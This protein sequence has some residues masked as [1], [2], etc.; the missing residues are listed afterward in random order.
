[1]HMK[2]AVLYQQGLPRP[3]ARSVP[4][5]IEDVDIEGPGQNEVLVQIA[6]AGLCH[7][8]LSGIEGVRARPLPTIVGHEA[9]GVVVDIG[10][11]VTR[12]KRGD[13]VVAVFAS[14]CGHCKYCYRSRPVLCQSSRQARA[15]GTLQSGARRLSLKGKKI[16]HYSALSTF[17]EYAVI[18]QDALVPVDKSV[19]LEVAA[20]FGCAVVTGV[21][22]V[23]NTANVEMGM[24]A[25][26]VGLG[27]VG[28]NAILGLV[29]V[30]ATP[31]VAVDLNPAKI[32]LALALGASHGVVA[33]T[34]TCVEEVRD[35]TGGGV[36]FAFEMAGSPIAL[37]LAYSL[38][39]RG[40]LTVS[41]GLPDAKK[42]VSYS[43]ALLVLEERAIKG[44]HMGGCVPHRDVPRFIELYQ[45]GR[46][47]VDRLHDGD[48]TFDQLN[49]G[50]D[51]LAAGEV[52][53]QT[54]RPQM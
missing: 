15:E 24:S 21:G 49:A 22:A 42:F 39:G 16:N 33:G 30:G 11:G 41:A 47:P 19:P 40:G 27:G 13:H 10:P 44:S 7:S 32:E 23:V 50:F 4:L 35:L 51:R 17:A 5:V 54:L 28:L 45:A 20:L 18:S 36:D 26:V 43:P 9:S 25:A 31:I 48:V 8:D 14:G 46:L 52:V 1:M 37:D 12:L 34:A 38:T 29:A 53:R 6:A 2:A 3:F